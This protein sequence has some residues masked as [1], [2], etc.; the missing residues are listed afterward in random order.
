MNE[1]RRGRPPF[2]I[3]LPRSPPPGPPPALT[4]RRERGRA[5]PPQPVPSPPRPEGGKWR[6]AGLRGAQ[7]G[8]EGPEAPSRAGERPAA[9]EGGT[10]LG[11]GQ[12]RRPGAGSSA[13]PSSPLPGPLQ[14]S[15]NNGYKQPPPLPSPPKRS[16]HGAG[17]GI[18]R[19]GG[20]EKRIYL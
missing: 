14:S 8:G 13:L 9:P 1:L 4:R 10:A 16:R 2:L 12:R 11:R 17:R 7:P 20:E 19:G 15:F 5:S 3:L 18:E 6:G